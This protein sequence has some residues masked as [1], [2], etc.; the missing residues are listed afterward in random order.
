MT[1]IDI[2]IRDPYI[3]VESETYYMYGTRGKNLGIETGGFDVY[4]S[5]DLVT[6]SEP[7]ECFDSVKYGMNGRVNW[8]PEV[9]KYQGKFYMFATFKI[10]S[11]GQFGTYILR[12]DSPLGPFVPHSD[13]VITPEDWQSLDG[14]L[15][16]SKTG[17]PYMVFCHGHSPANNGMICYVA[18]SDDLIRAV[19][20]PVTIFDS[21]T[22]PYATVLTSYGRFITDGPFLYRT[23]R[24]AL[25]MIWSSF[26]NDQYAEMLVRFDDGELNLNFT[27]LPPLV[28]NDSGHGMLF[29]ADG[30]LYLTVHNPNTTLCERPVFIQLE[31]CGSTLRIK[32]NT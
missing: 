9:H 15:Y 10:E 32:N 20:E 31:D 22:C 25:L 4:I 16:I 17:K 11:T 14:T 1:C 8:A 30:K 24:G 6:W 21:S 19:S 29:K 26:I 18:L 5:T 3:P 23:D 7:I 28:D 13:G 2:N 12:A 27:H